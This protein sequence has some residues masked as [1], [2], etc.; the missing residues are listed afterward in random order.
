MQTLE[1]GEVVEA[2]ETEGSVATL[3][4]HFILEMWGCDKDVINDA[5]KI[6]ELIHKAALDA[7]ATIVK[8]FFHQFRP[9]GV[10]GVAILAESHL[11]IHTWPDERYVAADIFTC[12]TTT[13]PELG[14]DSLIEGFNP[15]DSSC[16]ELKRGDMHTKR[17]LLV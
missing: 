14:I 4:K 15:E 11:S 9:A 12:G 6:M 5:D 3:S 1:S 7:K 16:M 13:K 17:A 10:T 2:V 8:S